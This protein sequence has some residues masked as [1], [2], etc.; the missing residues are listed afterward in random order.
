MV[1]W[2]VI[3]AAM[4]LVKTPT[5]FYLLRFLLGAAEAGFF[6]GVILYLTQWY[7]AER[8]GSVTA[9]FMTGIAICS[10]IGSLLSG[11]IMQSFDGGNGWA[12]WQWLLLLE[13][14]PA[15]LMGIYIFFR[16]T[17]RIEQASWLTKNE[18]DLLI[19]DM[20]RDSGSQPAGSF[21]TAFRDGRVWLGCL[22]Y[23]CLITGLYGIGFWLPTIISEMGVKTP[24]HIGLLTAVPY[25]AAAIG[26]VLVGRSADRL[27]ERR[28][29]V[30]V[31]ASLGALGLVLSI[32]L[33]G[34]LVVSMA[35][36]SL[37]TFGA[38]TAIPLFW[39]I[40]TAFLR[41]AAAA[42]GI[43]LINSFGNL[44]GFSSPYI[45][46]W[47]KDLTGSTASGIFCVAAFVFAGAVLII[48]T[49]PARL[50]NR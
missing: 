7:P 1:T 45:V 32:V 35:A 23:F 2:G 5:S 25:T 26:M 15:V 29:H 16:L 38:V 46:G 4:M 30:A 22:I 42:A 13:G 48:A 21:G 18:R 33:A 20:A 31:P 40:P 10:V 36:L 41:G 34:N 37:A 8:R 49:I 24:L 44:A 50:V 27:G 14:A 11:W 47:L 43:A 6:P 9:I 17:D 3:A 39:G 12:G 28:W 19:E